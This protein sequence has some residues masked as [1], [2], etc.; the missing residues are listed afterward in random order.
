MQIREA[1]TMN[2]RHLLVAVA[3]AA[4]GGNAAASV[5]D[6]YNGVKVGA[7]LPEFDVE[8]LAEAP[9]SGAKLMLI[10][11]W[12]TWCAPCRDEFP[13]LNSLHSQFNGRGLSVIGLTLESKATAQAFLPKVSI[14]Y[15]LGAAGSKPLQKQLGIKALPYAILVNRIGIIVWRGQASNLS[16]AEIER[17]LAGA[18]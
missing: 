8:Y 17:Y 3:S 13:H 5:M 2:R 12:A 10:D 7:K 4:L 9:S 11:F 18:A 16:T 6:W 15:K 14:Q 1:I